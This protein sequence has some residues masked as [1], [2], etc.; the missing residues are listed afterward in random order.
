MTKVLRAPTRAPPAR[1]I[2]P[3]PKSALTPTPKPSSASSSPA[4]PIRRLTYWHRA[5]PQLLIHGASGPI[6]EVSRSRRKPGHETLPIG[7][8]GRTLVCPRDA[9]PPHYGQSP[10]PGHP[11]R[12]G[13]Q[14]AAGPVLPRVAQL[15]G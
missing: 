9:C 14:S 7:G 3:T 10:A 6:I 15:R 2:P 1:P 13:T 5:D 11:R 8:F 12:P 4:L